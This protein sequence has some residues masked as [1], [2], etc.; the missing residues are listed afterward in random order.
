MLIANPNQDS[1]DARVTVVLED[2]STLS[3]VFTVP[4]TSR[5]T[6]WAALEF[7]SVSSQRFSAVVDSVGPGAQGLVVEVSRYWDA[8]DVPWAAGTNLVAT[9]LP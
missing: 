9:P 5:F 1:A 3:R 4:A 7:P 6:V 2:G 8:R